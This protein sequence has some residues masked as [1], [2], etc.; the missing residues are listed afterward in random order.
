MQLGIQQGYK[1]K[2]DIFKDQW[3]CNASRTEMKKLINN[4]NSQGEA[5]LRKV[6]LIRGSGGGW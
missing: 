4:C 1:E 5:A 2:E 3:D 6:S